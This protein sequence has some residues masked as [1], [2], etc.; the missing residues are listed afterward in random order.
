MLTI[1]IPD[2]TTCARCGKDFEPRK[3]G[4]YRGYWPAKAIVLLPCT[5]CGDGGAHLVI[6]DPRDPDSDVKLSK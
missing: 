3:V 4:I 5:F 6:D 1:S 2:Q